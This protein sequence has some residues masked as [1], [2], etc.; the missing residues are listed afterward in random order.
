MI[1]NSVVSIQLTPEN[2]KV[3][4]GDSIECLS[5]KIDCFLDPYSHLNKLNFSLPSVKD[6]GCEKG[7]SHWQ[8]GQQHKDP[9]KAYF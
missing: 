3:H 1:R 6:C 7:V 2:T 4:H 8:T 5:G 9:D